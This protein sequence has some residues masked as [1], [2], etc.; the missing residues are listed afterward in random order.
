MSKKYV[1]GLLVLFAVIATSATF[2][3]WASGITGDD[4]TESINVSIG[5]GDVVS[6]TVTLNV[7]DQ[8]RTLVPAGFEDESTTYNTTTFTFDVNWD[9]DADGIEGVEGTLTVTIE[10]LT[11]GT[12]LDAEEIEG[13]F[14][15]TITPTSA[16]ITEG[17][18]LEV[19]VTVFFEN[20]PAD[21]A[22]YDQVANGSLEIELKFSVEAN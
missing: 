9:G 10:D 22:M 14:T 17:E 13:M 7:T 12:L 4:S 6:T 16:T 20:E 15:I 8:G 19:T 5:Q 21:Q 18:T 1:V 3:F 2:A 11:L